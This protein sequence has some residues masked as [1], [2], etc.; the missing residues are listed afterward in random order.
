LRAILRATFILC[1][2][3][4]PSLIVRIGALDLRS[5]GHSQGRT[6]ALGFAGQGRFDE[7][8]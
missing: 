2:I 5:Y 3:P 1:R 8:Q 6:D 4:P 7:A